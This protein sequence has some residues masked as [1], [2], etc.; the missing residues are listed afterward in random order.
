MSKKVQKRY[1]F[2]CVEQMLMNPDY[3]GFRCFRVEIFDR[4][5]KTPFQID[6]VHFMIPE[7]LF[8]GLYEAIDFKE[9][10]VP[11]QGSGGHGALREYLGGK[12]D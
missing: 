11:I 12:N 9:A 8:H 3:K 10:D 6:E 2:N 4:E 1:Y 5:A 7:E